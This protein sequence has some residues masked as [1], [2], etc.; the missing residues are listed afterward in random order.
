MRNPFF[1]RG[2]IR[3]PR[4]FFG[5]PA[6]TREIMRLLAGTQNVSLVGPVKSGKTSLLLHA[7]RPVVLASYGLS[8]A[9]YAPVYLS[10]EG[11]GALSAEQFFLLMVRET[12][13]QSAGKISLVYP[14][15][16]GR[17]G[18]GFLELR[19]I[20]DQLEVAGDHL[21]FLLDEVEL[22]ARN[23]AFDLNFFS[24]LRHIAARPGVCFVTATERRLHEIE[25]ADREVGSPFADL[26]SVV[27]LKP[28]DDDAAW[29][30]VAA[31]AADAGVDLCQERELV[32]ELAGDYPYH[33]QIVAYEVFEALAQGGPLSAAQRQ[34]VASRAYE[35]VEPTLSVLWDRLPPRVQ[36]AALAAV[37]GHPRAAPPVD[38]LTVA[39]DDGVAP[40]N[41]LVARF[42][43][44]RQRD[45]TPGVEDYLAEE[46][47]WQRELAAARPD[48]ALVYG[49]VRVLTRAVE[50]RD[51]YARGHSEHVARLAAGIAREMGCPDDVVEGIRV[52]AR[53]H[54]IGHVSISDT[55]LLKPGPLSELETQIVRTHPLVGA[56]I[57]D[58]L[59][60]PWS[61]KPAVRYHHE[62]LDGSGYPEGLIGEEIP[63]GARVLAV[64]DVAAAMT[65]DRPYRPA[66]TKEEALAELGQHAGTRYDERAVAALAR[67]MT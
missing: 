14:R 8:P 26:F 42:L 55:I 57:L 23:P 34:W 36:E 16:Q 41:A 58:A 19:D 46:E 3:E 1:N 56:Q 60:F 6:E 45:H 10:F 50:A 38:G 48:R 13:Q 67:V 64:A 25:I 52:A 40:A 27:R 59:E 66:H 9:Q 37:G 62:R 2:P 21:V 53:L 49:V 24:A 54:D 35:Q 32:M 5:R 63:L 30:A 15:Y 28:L 18:I 39:R 51:R 20:L 7:A 17:E 47:R 31:L 44:E 61:V 12:A 43:A 33:L 11:L 65:A 22:A 4:F 29:A